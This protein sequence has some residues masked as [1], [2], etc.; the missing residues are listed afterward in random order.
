MKVVNRR[1]LV[2]KI[3]IKTAI[4]EHF[5]AESGK[6]FYSIEVTPKA[7]LKLD[8]NDMKTLPLF[9][10]ITWINDD[11]LKGKIIDS[12]ALKLSRSIESAEVVNSIAC[13]KLSDLQLDEFLS[14]SGDNLMVLRGGERFLVS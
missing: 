11:N 3:P 8:F 1:E 7:G 12:P 5:T 9:V 14:C 2:G 10:D 6:C 4:S 13:N